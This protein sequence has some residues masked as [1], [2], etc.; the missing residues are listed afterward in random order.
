AN[1]VDPAG[2]GLVISAVTQPASGNVAIDSGAKRVTYTPD[3]AF[4]GLVAFTYTARDIYGITDDALVAVVVS[5]VD[6]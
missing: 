2:G 3:P 6:E 1:D 4:T 5:A